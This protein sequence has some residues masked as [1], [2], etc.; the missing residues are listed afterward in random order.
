MEKKFELTNET[1]VVDGRI[2]HRIKS[3]RDIPG[4]PIKKGYL[5]GFVEKEENLSH[6]GNCWIYGN[7]R[8][9]GYARICN[10][11]WIFGNARISGNAYVYGNAWVSGNAWVYGNVHI[12]GNTW[13]YGNAHVY[14]NARVYGNAW[15][16]GD[17]NIKSLDDICYIS[18]F[19]SR[20]GH[21]TFFR[22]KDNTI[23]VK[24]GCFSG[25]L[26]EFRVKVKET[27]GDN[28]YAKEY[29]AIADVVELRLN[30]KNEVE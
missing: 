4:T 27:H 18:S 20:N 6:E 9:Y 10:N 14:G 5:G 25:T 15:V 26:D 23:K 11:A 8:V 30:R 19:G 12:S 24:C 7:A 3:L 28:Q 13:L 17:A 16:Y 22:C 29:L 2:L 21:T 1:I